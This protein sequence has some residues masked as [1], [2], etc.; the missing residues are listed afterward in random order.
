MALG[1]RLRIRR[2]LMGVT[3]KLLAMSAGVSP[4]QIAKY[5]CADAHMS[6]VM[7][8]K[9]SQILGVDIDY[10]FRGAPGLT[11]PPEPEQ[12]VER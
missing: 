11:T 1:Q 2:Q 5:E 6:V 3:Q 10:F 4:Q 9:L 12:R 8:W 7:L